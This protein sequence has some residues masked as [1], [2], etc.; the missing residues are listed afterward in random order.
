MKI[1]D[2]HTL[3]IKEL[4]EKEIKEMTKQYVYVLDILEKWDYNEDTYV[5]VYSKFEDALKEYKYR[6]EQM[7]QNFYE[8]YETEIDD[9]FE[10]FETKPRKDAD[11]YFHMYKDEDDEDE[12]DYIIELLKKKVR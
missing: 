5:V 7:K 6:I 11:G 1:I 9:D 10:I 12:Y 4:T 3:E 2:E 8:H